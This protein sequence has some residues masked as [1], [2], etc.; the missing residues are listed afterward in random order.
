MKVVMSTHLVW[1]RNDLR[2][3]DNPALADACEDPKAD[4][5]A[6]FI[7]TPKQ[8]QNHQMAARQAT[9]MYDNLLK[10]QEALAGLGIVLIYQTCDDFE[11]TV[12]LLAKLCQQ[13]QVDSLFFNHQ[14]E[15]N[16][17]Q[18]DQAVQQ[19]LANKVS[20]QGF[21]GNL[22]LPPLTV[23]TA[24][25]QMYKVFTPF[26]KAFLDQL[27]ATK[28]QVYAKPQKRQVTKVKP[29]A[30][31][32][33][34]YPKQDYQD[35]S[36]GEQSALKRL[37]SFCAEQVADYAKVRD[38][39]IRNGTSRLS[40]YL[41]LGVLSPNQC[42]QRLQQEYPLFW[43][44]SKSGAFTWFNELL[45]REFY[46]HLLVAYPKLSKEQPFVAWTERIVWR[47]DQA[48]FK[49]WQ[50]GKTGYPIVDAAMQQLN[51]TGWMHNRLRMIV[52]SFLVKDLLIDWR[53][54]ERYFISQLTDGNLAANN[55][56]WQWAAST[57][58]DA[59]P[60]FRIFNPTTQ[61]QRF[62][63]EGEFIRQWLP[64]LKEVPAKYIHTPH[65]W[66]DK[67]Q[68]P[69]DYPK[70]MVSHQEARKNTLAAFEA[71]KSK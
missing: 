65:T 27:L 52:A 51:Q 6:V 67:E 1:F 40:A 8:W 30:V 19:R 2:V 69:L 57:G 70:P 38:L 10:L 31:S 13:Y 37:A 34:D 47:N 53:W 20:C 66:A 26:K 24:N 43:Q 22:F 46:N 11:Q 14:Y 44:D 39:P 3:T 64:A 4:V 45:W 41:S 29:V 25:K 12:K 23:V 21:H 36:A 18:R 62:D 33:F 48:D 5:I 28:P 42:F 58:T 54:G 16:E 71:A 35:L 32:A 17:Q 56:G 49:K 60:H 61:G 68:Q 63:P 9:F 7:A 15:V 59:A 50:Q 55:G